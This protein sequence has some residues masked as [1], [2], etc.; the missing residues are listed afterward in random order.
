M[1][2]PDIINLGFF[3]FNTIYIFGVLGIVASSFIVWMLGKKDGF[4]EF[5]LL[6][7]F[8]VTSAITAILFLFTKVGPYAFILGAILPIF[9]FCRY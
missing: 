2:L 9:I 8:V 6:D 4:T 3:Q 5:K 7:L 1:H